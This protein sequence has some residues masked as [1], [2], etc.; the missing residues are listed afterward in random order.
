MGRA[1]ELLCVFEEMFD[2]G[3]F[4]F[5]ISSDFALVKFVN[6]QAHCTCSDWF[7]DEQRYSSAEQ[8]KCQAVGRKLRC[9]R[10]C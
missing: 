6:V 10:C 5:R 8:D 2:F 3:E 1:K 7:R 9:L 4:R